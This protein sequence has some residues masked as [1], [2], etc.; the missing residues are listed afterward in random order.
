MRKSISIGALCI[1]TLAGCSAE[2][3]LENSDSL[4]SAARRDSHSESLRAHVIDASGAGIGTVKFEE[5]DGNVKVKT[6]LESLSPGFHGM[7]IHAN[8]NPA[9][10]DGCVPTT[11]A[12]ADAH[13]N[14]EG[15]VHGDHAG[16]MPALMALDD[17]TAS[18]SFETDRVTLA[19]LAGRAVIVH[20]LPDNFHNIPLGTAADQY[21]PNSSAATALTDA[22]GNAGA[23]IACGVIE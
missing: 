1:L 3:A 11:F 18:L 19:E 8:D 22:T 12:S 17:G 5:E 14:P 6:S 20:A 23:R 13:L 21:T 4:Q 15:N 16:D 2:D 7:H 10:G 9:N